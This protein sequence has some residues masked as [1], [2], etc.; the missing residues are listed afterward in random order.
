MFNVNTQMTFSIPTIAVLITCHNRKEKTSKCL[1]HLYDQ[2]GLNEYFQIELF[3]VD[4]G[5]TDGTSIEIKD[6]FPLV[7]IIH[8]NGNLFWNKGMTLAW[9]TAADSKD[10]DY[11][12]WL[13]DDTFLDPTGL[14]ELIKTYTIAT[15][16]EHREVIIT[17][18]CRSD[19]N[20]DVFSYGGRN[21]E[22]PVIPNGTLQSCKYINGNCVLVPK[23]VYKILGNL[24]ED[25]T[26][27][28]GDFD[29]GLRALQIGFKCFTT[30]DYIATCEPNSEIAGWCNPN[31]SLL[32][33]WSLFHS[34]KGL[35]IRE[36][37]FFRKRFWGKKWI[38]FTVKAY[39]KM[40]F[41]RFYKISLNIT[42]LRC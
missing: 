9:Q 12:M 7:N 35:N 18:A 23:A 27:G 26:H 4:D 14:L 19:F 3:L 20:N 34:P 21:E 41:P 39:F 38:F 31:L 32:K 37:N 25:Y 13:N 24:S 2:R 16:F 17:A 5:S 11:Y 1:S 10:F 15:S 42:L 28:I 36:Y 40:L 8:G 30:K 33:R 22:G 6:K 29:Y